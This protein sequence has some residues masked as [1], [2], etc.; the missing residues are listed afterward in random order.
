MFLQRHRQ[1]RIALYEP[2]LHRSPD[3]PSFATRDPANKIPQPTV[4][5]LLITLD[6]VGIVIVGIVSDAAVVCEVVPHSIDA[7]AIEGEE[8]VDDVAGGL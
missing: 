4:K 5:A 3:I 2:F 7:E 1:S 6:N 8:R